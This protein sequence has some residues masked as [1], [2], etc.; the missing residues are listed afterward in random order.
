MMFSGRT[1][2]LPR[3][4]PLQFEEVDGEIYLA[5]ARGQEADWFKNIIFTDA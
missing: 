4:I 3:T 2:G 1:S 5:L